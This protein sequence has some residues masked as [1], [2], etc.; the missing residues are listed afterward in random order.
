MGQNSSLNDQNMFCWM[1]IACSLVTI[2]QLSLIK[3]GNLI[4]LLHASACQYSAQS[5]LVLFTFLPL[6]NKGIIINI[7][8]L[9]P[10]SIICL[11]IQ[12]LMVKWFWPLYRITEIFKTI[13]ICLTSD[14]IMSSMIIKLKK[15]PWYLFFIFF[16]LSSFVAYFL[17]LPLMFLHTWANDLPHWI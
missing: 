1:L 14:I 4:E 3:R 17:L 16:H 11:S 8:I 5:G 10:T 9:G 13:Q 6:S 15:M 2:K 12:I 7:Q